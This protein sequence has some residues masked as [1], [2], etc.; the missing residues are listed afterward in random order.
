MLPLLKNSLGQIF[1]SNENDACNS[2]L[3]GAC[4]VYDVELLEWRANCTHARNLR[5]DGVIMSPTGDIF[6]CH[7]V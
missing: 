1:D 4:D 2:A 3:I 5:G 6:D 7:L